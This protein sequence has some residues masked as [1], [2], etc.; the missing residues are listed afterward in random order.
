MATRNSNL[1]HSDSSKYLVI[2][3]YGANPSQAD[4]YSHGRSEEII[5]AAIK[6]FALPRESLVL[7]TKIFYALE[8]STQPP[9]SAVMDPLALPNRVGLSRKHILSAVAECCERLGTYIDLLQVHRYDPNVPVEETVKALHDVV[10]SGQVRY[11]G[12]SSMP[13]WQFQK[14]QNV[15]EKNGW[16]KFISM[17]GYYNL[18]YREEER[19]MIPYCKD[20]GIGLCQW[21]PLGRGILSRPWNDR[22]SKRDQSDQ[23]LKNMVR[24]KGM[25]DID[26]AIVGRVEEISKKRGVSMATVALAWVM[27]RGCFPI[28]GLGKKERIDEAIAAVSF[29]LTTEEVEFLEELYVP[30]AVM[31]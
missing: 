6:N 18:I 19:E 5:G 25:E 4:V 15:A 10:Q 2:H 3:E 13:A 21:S 1:G 11:I 7:M 26:Q 28:T 31:M 27:S 17:Q 24:G 12:A 22:T 9:I 29:V 8:P 20:A 30:K 14:M 23:L 16:T